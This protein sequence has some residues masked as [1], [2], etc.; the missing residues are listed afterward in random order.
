MASRGDTLSTSWTPID[1]VSPSSRYQPAVPRMS[2]AGMDQLSYGSVSSS[3]HGAQAHLVTHGE[4]GTLRAGETQ[5]PDWAN[6]LLDFSSHP[7]KFK[8]Q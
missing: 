6:G 8:F 2:P 7:S 3:P 1:R 5:I 4:V